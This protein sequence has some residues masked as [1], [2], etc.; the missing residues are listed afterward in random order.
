MSAELAA[1]LQT[2]G[3][4]L[5]QVEQLLAADPQNQQ[6]MKLRQDLLE[7]TKLTEDLLKRRGR[8]GAVRGGR[9]PRPA[10]AAACA[11]RVGPPAIV[12][13]CYFIL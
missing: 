4:Q 1:K 10:P 9:G 12:V 11:R 8:A 5:A 7:V 13:R 6:F 3:E 2:Y